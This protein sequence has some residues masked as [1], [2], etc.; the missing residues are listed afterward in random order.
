M[1]LVRQ[2]LWPRVVVKELDSGLRDYRF[3]T[4]DLGSN[5][6]PPPLRPKVM[7]SEEPIPKNNLPTTRVPCA[8]LVIDRCMSEDPR[9]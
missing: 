5:L 4:S 3:K 2:S 1:R 9:Q 8:A 6:F 7:A